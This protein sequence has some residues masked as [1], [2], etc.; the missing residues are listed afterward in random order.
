MRLHLFLGLSR[1]ENEL[2]ELKNE[3]QRH[4]ER[5]GLD[6]TKLIKA[7]VLVGALIVSMKCR[8]D[9]CSKYKYFYCSIRKV[10][11]G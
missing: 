5:T 3:L 7:L 1:S 11:Q 10:I 4:G 2:D 9:A 8:V 6:Q